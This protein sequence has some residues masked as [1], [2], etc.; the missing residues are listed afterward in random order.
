[1]VLVN[2]NSLKSSRP[3]GPFIPANVSTDPLAV[4]LTII[5]DTRESAPFTFSPSLIRGDSKQR[6]RPLVIR[7]IDRC[8]E[9]GDYSLLGFEDRISVER[10]SLEDL[11]G[12]LGH[13][14]KPGREKS[15][16]DLFREEHER[17]QQ[18]VLFGGFVAVVIEGSIEDVTDNPPTRGAY[19]RDV[20]RTSIRWPKRYGVTWLWAG[21]RAAAEQWTWEFLF[22]AWKQ[23]T[24][25]G[26]GTKQ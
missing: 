16:R 25:E 2:S 9:T 8:L 17:L 20:I 7:T 11:F 6:G 26:K 12:S 22:D 1:M 5:R 24:N 23:I 3:T 14:K 10:K 21:S 15:R 18:M 19:P 4:D 13:W